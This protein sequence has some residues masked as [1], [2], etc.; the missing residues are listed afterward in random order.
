MMD[1]FKL[2]KVT[3][4]QSRFGRSVNLERDFYDHVS[5]EGYVLTTTARNALSRLTQA[6]TDNNAAR[7]WTLTGAYG[8]GKSTFALFAAKLFSYKKNP[9][10][11]Q[12]QDFIRILSYGNQHLRKRTKRQS[13]SRFW[14]VDRASR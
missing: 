5:L 4:V 1:S 3:S 11:L 9:E 7:A 13:F 12:A 10:T 6:L 14:L 2:S 8:S